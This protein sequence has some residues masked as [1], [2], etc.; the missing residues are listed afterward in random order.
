MR[1][2]P[3]AVPGIM[4]LSGGMGAQEATE[5]LQQLQRKAECAPW[6]L[7][8]S[9][10][11]A[12]Q[13]SVLKAWMG[14]PENVPAAQELL[15]ELARVNGEAQQGVWNEEHPAAGSTRTALPKLSYSSERAQPTQL[16]NW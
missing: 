9:Y 12:L 15:L 5:N 2:V 10:G 3:P 7:S 11:R 14:K 16:F 8:F 6:T 4:F 13:D 1:T